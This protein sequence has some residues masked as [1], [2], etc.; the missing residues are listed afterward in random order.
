MQSYYLAKVWDKQ[1][2]KLP[3]TCKAARPT[4]WDFVT[5]LP[6]IHIV[7]A[8]YRSATLSGTFVISP[9]V[10]FPLQTSGFGKID[11]LCRWF[12]HRLVSS[13][14]SLTVDFSNIRFDPNFTG[15]VVSNIEK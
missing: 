12:N 10:I 11:V 3:Y 6:V 15:D 4:D 2:V 8:R 7:D 14:L 9:F 13:G 1:S 5:N